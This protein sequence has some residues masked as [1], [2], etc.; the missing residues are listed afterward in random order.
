MNQKLVAEMQVELLDNPK[1]TAG[2]LASV[3]KEWSEMLE[4]IGLEVE[5]K[6]TIRDG[7]KKRKLKVVDK[8]AA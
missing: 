2:I 5:A 1:Q 4:R 7:R 6:L 3:T 8:T